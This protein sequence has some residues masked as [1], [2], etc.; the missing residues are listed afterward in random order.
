MAIREAFVQYLVDLSSFDISWPLMKENSRFRMGDNR[1]VM[2]YF[3]GAGKSFNVVL[4]HEDLSDPA[5]WSQE[6]E[7]LL[8]NTRKEFEGWDPV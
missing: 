2:T 8:I 1:H 4:N 7:S 5:E 3:I 6:K